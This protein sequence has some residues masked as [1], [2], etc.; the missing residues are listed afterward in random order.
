[1]SDD[2]THPLGLERAALG[3][4]E[5][6]DQDR[7]AVEALRRA[8]AEFL[9]Q[10]PSQR[11]VAEIQRR[12][13]E[14]RGGWAPWRIAL[15]AVAM[16]ALV[17]IWV[18]PLPGEDPDTRSKGQVQLLIHRATGSGVE[19]LVNGD[20]AQAGDRLQLG[21]G[22]GG[23]GYGVI[24]SVDGA[25]AI[26]VHLPKSKE[27]G[28][29][30]LEPKGATLPFSYELDRAPRFERFFLITKAVPFAAEEI[31][32]A[33]RRLSSPE[34]GALP[35]PAGYEQTSLLLRKVEP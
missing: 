23:Q 28:A 17:A 11:V 32:A 10:H 25:G 26:T 4:A 9:E 16:A 31:D 30:R 22:P 1:M 19:K 12:H 35:L 6:K 34:A 8:N 29:A 27:E 14:R 5:T 2:R 33:L 13:Q 21:Y 18:R 7:A 3:E 15:P 24:A 20:L